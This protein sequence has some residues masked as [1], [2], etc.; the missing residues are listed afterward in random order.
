MDAPSDL[1]SCDLIENENTEH[2][3]KICHT[4][5][6]NYI[7]NMQKM[8][9]IVEGRSDITLRILDW[10]VSVYAYDKNMSDICASYKSSLAYYKKRYFDPF[11]RTDKLNHKYI[12]NNERRYLPTS[13]GQLNFFKWAFEHNVIDVV[14]ASL[15]QIET[16]MIDAEIMIH[17]AN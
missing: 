2:I 5:F 17:I 9:D 13:I 6:A 16:N 3:L 11:R 10:F 8:A 14:G 12:I 4:Y 1:T 7:E 15:P